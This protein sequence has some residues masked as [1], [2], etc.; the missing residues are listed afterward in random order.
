MHIH[1]MVKMVQT[2]QCEMKCRWQIELWLWRSKCHFVGNPCGTLRLCVKVG[3]AWWT[4]D[5]RSQRTA[6]GHFVQQW[7]SLD[8]VSWQMRQLFWLP[9]L[10]YACTVRIFVL[11]KLLLC[12]TFC[13]DWIRCLFFPR[14]I[15]HLRMITSCTA[16]HRSHENRQHWLHTV[17]QK[18]V[19]RLLQ[20]LVILIRSESFR[21]NLRWQTLR[22]VRDVDSE[23][24]WS[25]I[26]WKK[27]FL[28]V[29]V[30]ILTITLR[31]R[32]VRWTVG[33]NCITDMIV[34]MTYDTLSWNHIQDFAGHCQTAMLDSMLRQRSKLCRHS[35]TKKLDVSALMLS[36]K[37]DYICQL[38]GLSW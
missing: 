24:G 11:F 9:W 27:N 5:S 35:A 37:G 29:N 38:G 3:L 33:R 1:M 17:L 13:T 36:W 7:I 34:V 26:V 18:P 30:L 20:L 12:C 4:L 6:T 2:G 16:H 25:L 19:L 10:Q 22:V 23:R 31:V 8:T 14:C 15:T 32:S 21:L 28:T